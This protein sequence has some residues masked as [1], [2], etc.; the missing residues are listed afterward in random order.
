[1]NNQHYAITVVGE[2]PVLTAQ[3]IVADIRP[4]ITATPVSE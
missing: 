3:Q 1:M 2:I 4:R